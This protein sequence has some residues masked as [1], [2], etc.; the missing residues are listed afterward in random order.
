MGDVYRSD[1]ERL[2][3]LEQQDPTVPGAL[4][5]PDPGQDAPAA[6]PTIPVSDPTAELPP[7]GSSW[8]PPPAP[9]YGGGGGGGWAMPPGGISPPA[10]AGGPR[11]GLIAA[12]AAVAVLAGAVGAAL[13]INLDRRRTTSSS[14]PITNFAPFPNTPSGGTTPL[15][16]NVSSI[17]TKVDPAVVYIT[18]TLGFQNGQASG[19]GMVLTSSGEVLTNN[20]VVAGATKLNVQVDGSGP[21]YTAKILGTDP[22]DDVALI[23]M[24]GVSGLKTVKIGDSS[25]LSVGQQVVA[26]GDALGRAGPPAVTS[27]TVT[28]LNQSITA[29]DPGAGSAENLSGLIQTN[30]PLQQGD[31]GG[32]LVNTSAEVIGMDT[33]ASGRTRFGSFA[34]VAFAIPI[35]KAMS[36]V[37]QIRAGH[38]SSTVHVGQ[39]GFLGVGVQAVGAGQGNDFFGGGGTQA[40]PGVSSGALVVEVAPNTPAQ[41]AG[42]APGDVIVSFDGKPVDSPATLT[43]LVGAHHPG[44]SVE[45]G[46]VDSSGQ[47]HTAT[48]KLAAGPAD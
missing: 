3:T 17:A 39:A 34:N 40:P 10:P 24:Q 26:I 8:F 36:V 25:K 5:P 43:T 11:L 45:V 35:A 46:W 42:L 20:H 32:P 2:L 48:V 4:P 19:T 15:P 12:F 30:A 37:D 31:S 41:S 14:T 21:T 13:G 1:D 9:P 38:A 29:A 47:R 6:E 22:T 16:S 27:G 33:A 28:A 18:S 23:Q 7:T 44:D